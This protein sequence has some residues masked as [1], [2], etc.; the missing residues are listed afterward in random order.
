[1]SRGVQAGL[2]AQQ[3]GLGRGG[4]LQGGPKRGSL[5]VLNMGRGLG[6]EEGA[7]RFSKRAG[8][9]GGGVQGGGFIYIYMY[10]LS[11]FK[12]SEYLKSRVCGRGDSL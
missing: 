10:T 2:R 7:G 1:M 12:Y 3:T 6:R 4:Q 5:Q 11:D 9:K 8:S